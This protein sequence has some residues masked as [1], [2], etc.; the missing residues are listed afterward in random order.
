MGRSERT[1][2]ESRRAEPEDACDDPFVMPRAAFGL[3][4]LSVHAA[5]SLTTLARGAESAL[6]GTYAVVAAALLALH[7]VRPG[8]FARL[9]IATPVI[10]LCA[11]IVAL[12]YGHAPLAGVVVLAGAAAGLSRWRAAERAAREQSAG[13]VPAPGLGG[14]GRRGRAE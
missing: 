12:R 9:G 4:L 2:D 10:D 8:V 1:R 14:A 7:R 13:T 5:F 11:A 3:A 6:F